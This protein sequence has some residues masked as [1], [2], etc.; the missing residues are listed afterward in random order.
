MTAQIAPL[1]ERQAW[2]TLEAHHKNVRELH[3]RKLF[4]D[5]PTRGERMTLEGAGLY[6]DYSKNRVI[7]ET[8]QLLL[9][10]AKE[11]GLEARI[12]AMLSSAGNSACSA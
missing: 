7:D 8:L 9:Q 4:A 11:S 6:L 3:L 10:L 2:K 1:T 5:D 12:D